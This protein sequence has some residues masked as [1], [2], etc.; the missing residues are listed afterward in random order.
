ME[1]NLKTG[2]NDRENLDQDT[3]GSTKDAEAAYKSSVPKRY[4]KNDIKFGKMGFQ[5]ILTLIT[6][7]RPASVGG[8]LLFL[9]HI[10]MLCSRFS[11]SQRRCVSS[12]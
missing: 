1:Y 7:T 2:H 3:D 12:Y 11:T 4:K 5:M 8:Q 9:I 6:P 10:V